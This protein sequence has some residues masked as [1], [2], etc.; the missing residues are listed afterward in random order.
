[1]KQSAGVVSFE[2]QALT[3]YRIRVIGN[4]VESEPISLS[5]MMGAVEF[6]SSTVSNGVTTLTF[7]TGNRSL[8]LE[9]SADLITWKRAAVFAASTQPITW[10]DPGP[11]VTDAPGTARFYR[12]VTP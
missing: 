12:L 7:A 9:Y 6:I 4:S 2:A 3:T 5:L 10:S 8:A 11:P 1:M